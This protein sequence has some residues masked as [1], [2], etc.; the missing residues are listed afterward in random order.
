MKRSTPVSKESTNRV[1]R[2]KKAVGRQLIY[3]ERQIKLINPVWCSGPVPKEFWKNDDNQRNYL[4]WLA[5]RL[6]YRYMEDWYRVSYDDFGNNHGSAILTK[7]YGGSPLTALRHFFPEYN[8]H[9]WLFERVS[10]TFWR[11]REN[12]Q[13]YMSWLGEQL[14]FK[15]PEDWYRVTVKD[16]KRHHGISMLKSYSSG[17]SILSAITDVFPDYPWIP[18]LFNRIPAGYYNDRANRL[19]YLRWLGNRLGFKQ[20]EDWYQL[21]QRDFHRNCGEYFVYYQNG[22][23][24]AAKD[25]YPNYPWKEWM[26]SSVP[27]GFWG[28]PENQHRYMAWLGEQLGFK[29]PEDW[30]HVRRKDFSN[31]YGNRLVNRYR[32][33][34]N[35]LRHLLP[36]FDWDNMPHIHANRSQKRPRRK[37]S[38]QSP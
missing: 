26:F 36:D 34:N 12:C 31:N 9:D 16:F 38:E 18:W 11:R 5:Q 2:R 28:V 27:K 6:Q 22:S 21:K 37:T 29:K 33:L 35:L 4:L 23:I 15:K 3:T 30:R 24:Q 10:K 14:G 17:G 1:Q 25:L 13:N 19:R 8:W 32:T 7:Y 20:P